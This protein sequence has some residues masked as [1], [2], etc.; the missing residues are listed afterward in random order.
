MRHTAR[1]QFKQATSKLLALQLCYTQNKMQHFLTFILDINRE[2]ELLDVNWSQMEWKWF[3]RILIILNLN[4]DA[5]RSISFCHLN[6]RN[7]A[8]IL[9][10]RNSDSGVGTRITC[11]E[12]LQQGKILRNLGE[13]KVTAED[14]QSRGIWGVFLKSSCPWSHQ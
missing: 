13:K 6:R 7:R 3:F 10:S 11:M 14:I 5:D 1:V 4:K 9:K 2:R 12:N 8:K